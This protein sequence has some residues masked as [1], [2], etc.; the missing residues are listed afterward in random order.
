MIIMKYFFSLKKIDL[1][2][3]VKIKNVNY[4]LLLNMDHHILI[5]RLIDYFIQKYFISIINQLYSQ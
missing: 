3:L 1:F 4:Y 2:K 5:N